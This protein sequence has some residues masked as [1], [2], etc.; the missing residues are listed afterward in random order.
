MTL[1]A[2]DAHCYVPE[3]ARSLAQSASRLEE[4]APGVAAEFRWVCSLMEHAQHFVLPRG[5]RL[6][7]DD[8]RSVA[9]QLLR[10]PYPI[11][12]L[13]YR[14][15]PWSPQDLATTRVSKRVDLCIETPAAEW[16]TLIDGLARN[17][18]AFTGASSARLM[19][20]WQRLTSHADEPTAVLQVFGIWWVD[21]WRTW[22]LFPYIGVSPN[23]AAADGRICSYVAELPA[24]A[25][26]TGNAREGDPARD[27]AEEIGVAFDLCEALRC[28]N[29]SAPI[30]KPDAR[31]ASHRAR[32]GKLP[33][34]SFHVLE[35]R[36][37][38]AARAPPAGGHHASPRTHLRRGHVRQL[39]DGPIW[40]NACLVNPG[41]GAVIKDYAIA[42]KVR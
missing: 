40:V 32:D 3:A 2:R 20:E 4:S 41:H 23:G 26:A 38:S 27:M 21:E 33:L 10:M 22:V 5:G 7:D 16:S 11:T 12:T 37:A 14:A 31:K 39:P 25:R 17:G 6:I 8:L 42:T 35:V 19:S 34:V 24:M 30:V 15:A 13:S 9:G 28:T 1:D 29:V 36:A 18:P